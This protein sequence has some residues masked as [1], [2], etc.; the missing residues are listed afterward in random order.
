MPTAL[1]KRNQTE[2]HQAIG[3]FKRPVCIWDVF[4]SRLFAMGHEECGAVL[5]TS[6]AVFLLMYLVCAGILTVSTAVRERIHLQNAADAAAYS[7]A[8]IQ[9]D[10]ISRIATINRA[11]AWTYVQ[12][13]RRQMD[14]IVYKWLD[15][16]YAHY[17]TDQ[18][19]ARNNH[20]FSGYCK[21]H[22]HY[23]QDEQW[24]IKA[25]SNPLSS[26]D[27]VQLNGTWLTAVPAV[28]GLTSLGTV[29]D[30]ETVGNALTA[31]GIES[32]AKVILTGDAVST[33]SLLT[34]NASFAAVP[35]TI[36]TI[37]DSVVGLSGGS[38]KAPLVSYVDTI[39]SVNNTMTSMRDVV[40]ES[41]KHDRS[42]SVDRGYKSQIDRYLNVLKAQ[43][44]C[45]RLSI[46][47]MNIYNRRLALD[48]PGKIRNCVSD[49]LR[50]NIPHHLL[51]RC[52]YYLQQNENPLAW[53]EHG[54]ET[55]VGTLLG[56]YFC[57]LHNNPVDERRFI[58]FADYEKSLV[59]T[60]RTTQYLDGLLSRTAGG[61]DQWFVRG[62][63]VKRTDGAVG[64]QRS[65]KHWAEGPYASRHMAYNPY[66]PS[67][68]NT[69]QLNASP[70][71]IALH[72]Q[73]QWYARNW[74]CFYFP[75]TPWT[76]EFDI[77]VPIPLWTSCR[78]HPRPGVD[79]LAYAGAL[80][81]WASGIPNMVEYV[82]GALDGVEEDEDGN[83]INPNITID[84]GSKTPPTVSGGAT[85]SSS[86]E[87]YEYGCLTTIDGF[88]INVIDGVPV[89]VPLFTSYARIY[90][91]DK[92]LF[93]ACYV[94]ECAKPLV[95]RKNYFGKDGSISVGIVCENENPWKRILGRIEGIFTAFDPSVGWSWVFSTAKAGYKDK[96]AD[97]DRR[98]YRIEWDENNQDWNLCQTDWDAVFV[99]VRQSET[100]AERLFG[101][102]VWTL[103]SKSFLDKWVGETWEPLD[104]GGGEADSLMDAPPGMVGAQNRLMWRDLTDVMYH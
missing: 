48:M 14:Y 36:Q 34:G 71:S 42:Y 19:T 58:R 78:F 102:P 8:V 15:C 31:G 74:F 84:E 67:C 99:P 68:W 87:N 82:K 38:Y 57:N 33:T 103:G 20:S 1:S 61:F 5:V 12:M 83:P 6:L 24:M 22:H 55:G 40:S 65:Y 32:L 27:T 52:H 18:E 77:H 13:S 90:G 53:E 54:T 80:V 72:S 45:D 91:D 50:A 75:P 88:V 93:N 44:I 9:A 100:Q 97:S 11:M 10:T 59:E 26:R 23:D 56:G 39:K 86:V 66:L 73:W 92:H 43:I 29:T 21:G 35:A 70:S 30:I 25:N 60:F 28:G 63:G 89:P 98:D 7:A 69:E 37:G 85:V 3:T 62:D 79:L 64:L 101:L 16:T 104:G 17:K 94:G 96:G 81:Q 76:G 4:C 51:K 95:V 49:V 47:A 41:M 46:A 2:N